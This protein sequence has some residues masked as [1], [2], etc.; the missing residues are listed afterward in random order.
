MADY[1]LEERVKITAN[2]L[3][4]V[5]AGEFFECDTCGT[6]SPFV[7]VDV[8]NGESGDY[9]VAYRCHKCNKPLEPLSMLDYLAC[10][11]DAEFVTSISG[12][13]R[14]G[15]VAVK[16]CAYPCV[17]DTKLGTITGRINWT[18]IAFSIPVSDMVRRLV[19]EVLKHWFDDMI[20]RKACE[21]K[22][23]RESRNAKR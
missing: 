21:L 11:E 14:S 6:A 18:T 23:I 3:E 5:A 17:V 16:H 2:E 8:E 15:N 9:G 12:E 19:D 10:P 7:K 20:M 22:K 1:R 4:A 13:Y